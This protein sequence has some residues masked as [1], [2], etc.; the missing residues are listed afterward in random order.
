MK[1]EQVARFFRVRAA[2]M[3][4][5]MKGEILCLLLLLP[6]QLDELMLSVYI[7]LANKSSDFSLTY[8][9]AVTFTLIIELAIS[10][11]NSGG[12]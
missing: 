2:T 5:T 10:L 7:L 3:A 6:S 4:S 11:A 12:S 8:L 9:A 1:V